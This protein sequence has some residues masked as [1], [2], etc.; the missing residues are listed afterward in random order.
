R[1][2]RSKRDWSS[3]VCSSD[4]GFSLRFVVTV[5]L[6]ISLATRVA[7]MWRTRTWITWRRAAALVGGAVPGLWVG[8]VALGRVDP[9]DVRVAA[10]SEERRVGKGGDAGGASW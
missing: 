9:R 5:N 8:S 2:T 3:D 1:H 6:L 10:R 4:L 7:V